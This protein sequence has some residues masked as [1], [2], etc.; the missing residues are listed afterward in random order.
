M[1]GKIPFKPKKSFVLP[2][3]LFIGPYNP[4]HLQRDSKDNPL[5]GNEPHNVG[6]AIS[7]RHDIC[8]RDNNT[9]AGKRECDRK[10]L[11]EL[12]ALVPKDRREKVDRQLVRSIT[13]LK[14]RMGL[15][16]HWTNQLANELHKYGDDLR[17]V[18]YSLNKSMIYGLQI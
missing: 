18:L 1:I 8:S 17:N 12:N 4:L 10:M 6:D 7:T 14:H 15:G 3:H 2:N 11:A 13:G 5:P 16:I 9:S